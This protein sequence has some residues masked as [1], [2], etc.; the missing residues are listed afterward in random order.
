M[1]VES[2][3]DEYVMFFLEN[4]LAGGKLVGQ[5]DFAVKTGKNMVEL[6]NHSPVMIGICVVAFVLML[7]VYYRMNPMSSDFAPFCPFHRLTGLSCPA[8]GNQRALHAVLHGHF[9]EGIG[10]N[11]FLNLSVP[12]FLAI[13]YGEVFG[14]QIAEHIRKFTHSPIT[15]SV[16]CVLTILWWV[17]R[18]MLMI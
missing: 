10:Y 11:L 4:P 12:Y 6:T 7:L 15:I 5:N 3:A 14:G 18:N 9:L 2:F 8:C 16:F 13:L 17:I 1:S